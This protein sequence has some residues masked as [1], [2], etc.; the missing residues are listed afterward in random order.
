MM[1][2][3]QAW[4]LD[5]TNADVYWGFGNLLGMKGQYKESI[6]LFKKSISLNAKNALVWEA[7]SISYIQVFFKTQNLKQLDTCIIYLKEAIKLDNK[8]AG[9][10]AELATAYSYFY[11]KDSARKYMEITDKLDVNAMDPQAREIIIKK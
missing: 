11:Q 8:N 3:N 1:R 10:F 2:F 6:S 7:G 5:R 4:L 9:L